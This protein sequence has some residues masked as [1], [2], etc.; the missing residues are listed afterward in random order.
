V[1]KQCE[2]CVHG[3]R[4]QGLV[5]PVEKVDYYCSR[6]SAIR[7]E[8][9]ADLVEPLLKALAEDDRCPHFDSGA[10]LPDSYRAVDL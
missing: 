9:V 5:I 2:L 1:C 3:R 7:D 8:A 10:H 4:N 6:V